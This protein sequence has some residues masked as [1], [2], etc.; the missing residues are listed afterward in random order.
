[1]VASIKGGSLVP[2]WRIGRE[3]DDLFYDLIMLNVLAKYVVFGLHPG[4][5]GAALL[6]SD[7]HRLPGLASFTNPSLAELQHATDKDTYLKNRGQKV[8]LNMLNFV[9]EN[10]HPI[11]RGDGKKLF[12]WMD[13]DGLSGCSK[14]VLVLFK[15]S[16]TEYW[17]I[18][19]LLDHEK[20][21]FDW[22]R[23]VEEV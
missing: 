15:L 2:G 12:N 6:C 23:D 14:D 3:G 4:T 7:V 1:M 10:V 8:W 16:S 21:M 11:C 19:H 5:F 22:N 13:H 18:D 17:F 20:A 9:E